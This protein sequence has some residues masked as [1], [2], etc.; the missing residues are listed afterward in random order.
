MTAPGIC[1]TSCI[2]VIL[3]VEEVQNRDGDGIKNQ[4]HNV[5]EKRI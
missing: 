3:A 4:I 2:A 5:Q 1:Q